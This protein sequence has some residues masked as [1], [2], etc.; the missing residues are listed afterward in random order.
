MALVRV[1]EKYQVVIPPH[2]R[3]K[4]QIR[5]GDLEASVERGK[6]T[7]TPKSIVD[8]DI[9]ISLQQLKDGKVSPAFSSA[10]DL[11]RHLHRQAKKLKQSK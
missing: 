1:K 8:R 3:G 11:V 6:I 7:F 4:V 10:R 9:E 2:V 5:V